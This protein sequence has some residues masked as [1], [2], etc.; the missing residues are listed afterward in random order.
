MW[1]LCPIS[2]E[3]TDHT[4]VVVAETQGNTGRVGMKFIVDA[5]AIEETV[6]SRVSPEKAVQS[7]A[8]EKARAVVEKYQS[9]VVVGADTVVVL[10]NKIMGKPANNEDALDML[11]ELQGRVH[12]VHTGVAVIDAMTGRAVCDQELTYVEFGPMSKK[13][14]LKY[15]ATGGPWA[16]RER[17]LFRGWEPFL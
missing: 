8:L 7:L 3:K 12:R 11:L 13:D 9:G 10:D 16:R 4:G 14:A 15:I 2:Q 17:M 1:G 5:P 6:S